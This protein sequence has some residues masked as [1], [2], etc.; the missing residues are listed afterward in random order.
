MRQLQ[1]IFHLILF[2][3]LFKNFTSKKITT[4]FIT[5][6]LILLLSTQTVFAVT[7]DESN[8]NSC[9]GQQL[10]DTAIYETETVTDGEADRNTGHGRHD[11]YSIVTQATGTIT[12]S[13][14]NIDSNPLRLRVRHECSS[15]NLYNSQNSNDQTVT[16]TSVPAGQY[17]MRISE[18]NRNYSRYRLTVTFTPDVSSNTPNISISPTTRTVDQGD[19]VNLNVNLSPAGDTGSISVDYGGS[20]GA[21]GTV[22]IAQG[23]TSGSISFTATALMTTPCT[24]VLSNPV[25]NNGQNVGS[26]TCSTSTITISP[27]PSNSP[28]IYIFP[29]TRTVDQGYPVNLDVILSPAGDT[30]SISVDYAGTCGA[31]GTVTVPQGS[32]SGSISFTATAAMTTP[33]TVVLS[34]P[35]GNNGQ[36]IG[37]ITSSTSTITITPPPSNSPNISISPTSTQTPEGTASV[38]L[39][40]SLSEAGNT[41]SI[42]VDYSGCGISSTTLNFAQGVDAPQSIT[43]DTSSMV[44]GDSCD[45]TL[46][47][48]RGTSGGQTVGNIDPG[49]ST[50]T[51]TASGSGGYLPAL[52]CGPLNTFENGDIKLGSTT[53]IGTTPTGE[54]NTDGFSNGS[55]YP[56][57][58]C[59]GQECMQGAPVPQLTITV[60]S[61]NGNDGDKTTSNGELLNNS[62]YQFGK[63]FVSKNTATFEDTTIKVQDEFKFDSDVTL[64]IRGNVVIHV[65]GDFIFGSDNRV[66]FED[67]SSTL[68]VYVEKTAETGSD[69]IANSVAGYPPNNFQILAKDK[70][71]TGSHSNMR[72]MIY[73]ET[74]IVLGSSSD[75]VG[76]ATAKYIDAGSGVTIDASQNAGCGP[77]DPIDPDFVQCGLFPGA[78]NTWDTIHRGSGDIVLD[79]D[80]VYADNGVVGVGNQDIECTLDGTTADCL[81]KPMPEEIPTLPTFIPSPTSGSHTANGVETD[82]S[83]GDVTVNNGNT[84]TFTPSGTYT[85]GKPVMLIN[86]INIEDGATV[87]F[88]EGDY[89]IGSWT[90]AQSVTIRTNGKVRLFIDNDLDLTENH[91]DFN[92]DNNTGLPANMFIFIYGNF[93]FASQGGGVQQDVVAYVY[94][95]GEYTGNH[96]TA[97][98]HFRGA[99]T[100]VNNI[101]LNN[102]HEYTYDDSGLVDGWGDCCV[103]VQWQQ[104]EYQVAEDFTNPIPPSKTVNTVIELP[105]GPVAYD[106]QVDYTTVDATAVGGISCGN[107]AVD[108]ITASGTATI[109]AGNSTVTVPITICNDSP[110]ELEQYFYVDLSNPQPDGDVCLGGLYRTQVTILAQEDAPV[111]FENDFGDGTGALDSLWRVL[112]NPNSGNTYTPQV[113]SVNGDGRLRMTDDRTNLATV[114]TKDYTFNTTENLI[115]VEFD[116]YAYGGCNGGGLGSYGADGIVSV[117]F[118]SDVGNSPVPGAR[119]GALGFAQ[120]TATNPNQDGFEGGWLGLGLDEYGNYSNPNEGK[121][122][123][124]G[125]RTNAVSIRGD[126]SGIS[127]YE[128]LEGTTA[129]TPALAQK[130]GYPADGYFSG[131]YKMTVDARD[132]AHLYIRL[133]RSTTGND[134]DYAVI[135][136]QFDA[137]DSGYGQGQTPELV[138]YAMTAGTGGG[139]NNHE[140]SWIKL[141]GNCE[142]YAIA[143]TTGPFDA[144]DTFRDIDDRNIS[145][146]VVNRDF[147]LTIASINAQN[148]G[149]HI[150]TGINAKYQLEDMHSNAL[151][152]TEGDFNAS[153][154]STI[155]ASFNDIDSA[156]QDVRV[157]FEVCSDFDILTGVYTLFPHRNCSSI[158]GLTDSGQ[159]WRHW[160]SSDNLAIRPDRFF[161]E[162]P[163]ATIR[164]GIGYN[165]DYEALDAI[166]QRT[167]GYSNA[168]SVSTALNPPMAGCLNQTIDINS[169]LA[170]T[171]G[172]HDG[173]LTAT[174][175]NTVGDFNITLYEESGSEFASVDADDTPFS[176]SEALEITPYT[177]DLLHIVPA[178]F[179]LTSTF[180]NSN[181]VNNFTYL[182]DM[183]GS[184]KAM[185]A[186][187]N[188]NV[189]A[190]IADGSNAEN[191]ESDC[192]AAATDFYVDF[193]YTEITPAA[194]L[195]ELY[196]DKNATPSASGSVNIL[197]ASGTSLNNGNFSMSFPNTLFPADQQGSANINLSMNF[198]RQ[199]N[200][201]VNPLRLRINDINLTE[202][203]NEVSSEE[204]VDTN[205]TYYY[206]RVTSSQYFY[207][208]ITANDIDTPI[209]A[210]VYCN[211]WAGCTAFGIDTA[212]GQTDD[213]EWWVSRAHNRTLG[214]GNITLITPIPNIDIEGGTGNAPFIAPNATNITTNGQDPNINVD[215]GGSADLPM[216]V[217]IRLNTT[218]ETLTSPWMVYNADSA[219]IDP[220]PFYKVRFKDISDWAGVGATGN[221]VDTNGSTQKTR[222]LNW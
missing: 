92:Y 30:G 107:P 150:K 114:V 27:P 156:H 115:I 35:V 155:T 187:L 47:D 202:D 110:I 5:P 165:L 29:A 105:G 189:Q 52:Y 127:G 49:I 136:S 79:G 93:N 21:S 57:S 67:N 168:P 135:I 137:K 118:D 170:M 124:P 138:R 12:I 25:G 134:N 142:V 70:I 59:D 16:L 28:D 175:F 76:S 147:D 51:V 125:F 17:T 43:V 84:V 98:S 100:A 15:P 82:E 220:N 72:G 65:G 71:T 160:H 140:L 11:H 163:P 196:Y 75:L 173:N 162:T 44:D 190:M 166:N 73:S 9:P 181:T 204:L 113:V 26:I 183:N 182:H 102:N 171:N 214:D 106:V 141:R 69:F 31:S 20:C 169:S 218:T 177:I 199:R 39:N 203:D 126:G 3:F 99:V 216:E 111:C 176:T 184:S 149:V 211:L 10:F 221:V 120:M 145:T 174:H 213:D 42:A 217:H 8:N 14:T 90:S 53:V 139:C 133:E 143:T 207:D 144:W 157:R 116:Y 95:E 68:V 191:Y 129:L 130:N 96:N 193:N 41:G 37:S 36:N 58:T 7:E 55:D 1:I 54:V 188:V 32:T 132:P 200:L 208:D 117:L 152:G 62:L 119:G 131:R 215:S 104:N 13:L 80:S 164:A 24:V 91:L 192:Y 34:N 18:N 206:G 109:F 89:W 40:V 66:V 222:R 210:L 172:L 128:Y 123:G 179:N 60:D 209:I 6:F 180:T 2:S 94:V 88:G 86:S 195:S 167:Q 85:N 185:S 201:P 61:G 159:C 78:L 97:N 178:D 108:Y 33:C 50:I 153:V 148:N 198:D 219:I 74:E 122:G 212:L 158:C 48:L 151:L 23:S 38:T 161:M 64:T 101:N 154:D 103:Y 45:V 121:V 146:K 63:M 194:S 205:A 4:L 77:V 81:I 56:S 46:S 112:E 19:P 186:D 197:T 83:Y 22:N 87:T